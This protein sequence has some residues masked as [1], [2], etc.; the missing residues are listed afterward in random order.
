MDVQKYYNEKGQVAVLFSPGFGAG[1]STWM[2]D[3]PPEFSTMDK[4]LVEMAT[5]KADESEVEEYLAEKGYQDCCY[6]G[7]WSSI[8]VFFLNPGTKFR[9][10]EYDGSERIEYPDYLTA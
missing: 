1:W 8:T 6:L 3:I 5:R 10:H 7:G 2:R 4:T 9:I